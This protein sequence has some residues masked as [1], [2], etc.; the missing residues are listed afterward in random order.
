MN[1]FHN[2]LLKIFSYN[3]GKNQDKNQN[4]DQEVDLTNMDI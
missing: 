4:V 2:S 1:K 3:I